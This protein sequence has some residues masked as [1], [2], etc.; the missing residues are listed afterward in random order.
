MLLIEIIRQRSLEQRR[1]EIA[2]N[3]QETL[4]AVRQKRARIGNVKDLQ[5]DLTGE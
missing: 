1:A 5:R 4:K 3:A 2:Q